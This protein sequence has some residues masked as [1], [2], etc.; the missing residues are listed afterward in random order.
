[1]PSLPPVIDPPEPLMTPQEYGVGARF[2][3]AVYDSDYIDIILGALADTPTD[4]LTVESGDI[5]TFVTGSEQRISEYL[6]Q[7]VARAAAGG[8]HVS[9]AIL[10]SRG[11]PGEL[12]C[13][14]PPGVT[15]IG[16]EPV[17]LRETGIRARAHWSIYPLLNGGD[18]SAGDHM[19]PIYRA[20][21]RARAEGI[22]DGSDHFATRLDGDL[23]RVLATVANAWIEVGATVQHVVTH[24]TVSLN[25]PTLGQ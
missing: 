8:V 12:V 21:E 25:S 17:D 19:V 15:A 20:I 22:Y 16:A 7:V 3:L 13:E 6:T 14:L 2:T 5:S 10:L 18:E 24:V 23:A 11:C 4:G 1:M 9:A